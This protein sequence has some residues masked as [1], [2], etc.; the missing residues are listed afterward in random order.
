[1][2]CNFDISELFTLSKNIL[3][4]DD[5]CLKKLETEIF[6]KLCFYTQEN[7]KL[8]LA[9]IEFIAD[10][11]SNLLLLVRD[12]LFSRNINSQSYPYKNEDSN[13]FR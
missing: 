12:E 5:T 1:M 10:E 11:Y 9:F 13:L 3:D 7:E 2:D 6:K 4:T 8:G